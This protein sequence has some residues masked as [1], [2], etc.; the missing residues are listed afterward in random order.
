MKDQPG[1]PISLC[2]IPL[3]LYLPHLSGPLVDARQVDLRDKLYR[4]RSVRVGVAAVDVQAVYPVLVGTLKE[5]AWSVRAPQLYRRVGIAHVVA[6]ESFR[7]NSTSTDRHRP[8]NRTSKPL[9][10]EHVSLVN[11]E[12]IAFRITS[13][14]ALLSLLQL[15][16]QA[17]V[18]R[19]FG[20]HVANLRQIPCVG[21][22]DI[23]IPSVCLGKGEEGSSEAAGALDLEGTRAC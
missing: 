13:T 5:H 9:Y 3:Y 20:S 22:D 14:E 1:R 2:I 8:P 23:I 17:E 18:S 10:H 6:R 11:P 21:K 12:M 7:S 16:E 4:W 15:L 19:Y